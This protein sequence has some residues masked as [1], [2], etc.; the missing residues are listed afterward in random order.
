MQDKELEQMKKE[1][2]K[3]QERETFFLWFDNGP[4]RPE[5]LGLD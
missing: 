4:G 2:R 3:K 1:F 5:G